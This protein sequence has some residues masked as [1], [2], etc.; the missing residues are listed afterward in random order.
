MEQKRWVFYMEY[1]RLAVILYLPFYSA[2]YWQIKTAC[3]IFVLLMLTSYYNT[4]QK[5]YYRYVLK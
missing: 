5:N 1:A 3:I 2:S 4:L